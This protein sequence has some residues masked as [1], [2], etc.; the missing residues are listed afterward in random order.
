[1]I[2]IYSSSLDCESSC[3]FEAEGDVY[4]IEDNVEDLNG[5]IGNWLGD[6]L[7]YDHTFALEEKKDLSL[8]AS[9]T[10]EITIN[11][12]GT[13]SGAAL[14]VAVAFAALV[15]V[16]FA[17]FIHRRLSNNS[18]EFSEVQTTSEGE[19]QSVRSNSV[20]SWRNVFD[21]SKGSRSKKDV[22]ASESQ[23]IAFPISSNSYNTEYEVSK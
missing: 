14:G 7:S 18:D 10:D 15:F 9:T 8:G 22:N 20:R 23:P 21:A 17:F 13:G 12:S 11:H 6:V 2:S 3:K 1:M 19:L 16:G 4:Y 5:E